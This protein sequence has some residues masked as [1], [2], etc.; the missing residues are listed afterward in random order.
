VNDPCLLVSLY[1]TCTFEGKC[2]FLNLKIRDYKYSLML[3]LESMNV[4]VQY[5][6]KRRGI[7]IYFET[8]EKKFGS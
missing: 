4:A 5:Y 6:E 8:E 2:L 3:I 1:P 7:I